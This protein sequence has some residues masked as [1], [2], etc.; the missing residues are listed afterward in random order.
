MDLP[1][2]VSYTFY[3]TFLYKKYHILKTVVYSQQITINPYTIYYINYIDRRIYAA[4]PTA[5]KI[6]CT[7][8]HKITVQTFRGKVIGSGAFRVATET[9]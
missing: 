5:A 3:I 4:I 1:R 9:A 7:A 8:L 2:P 6:K